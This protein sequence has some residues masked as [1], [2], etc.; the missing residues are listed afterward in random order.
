[1]S[2]IKEQMMSVALI[3]G[4]SR[5]LGRALAWALAER[6]WALVLDARGGAPL[7]EVAAELSS[8]SVVA[9][10]GDLTDSTHRRAL[11]EAT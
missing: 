6:G 3:T 4:S 7:R 10:E 5:S 2:L 11:V 8:D 9:L 1:M